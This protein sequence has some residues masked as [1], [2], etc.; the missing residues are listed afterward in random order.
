MIHG[1]GGST[2]S[3]RHQIARLARCCR[4]VAVDLPGFGYSDRPLEA[5]L[6]DRPCDTPHR[7]HQRLDLGPATI[8]GHSMGA[9]IAMRIA[10][11]RP[12]LVNRLILAA[13]VAPDEHLPAPWYTL[14]RPLAPIRWRRSG[15]RKGGCAG[16]PPPAPMTRPT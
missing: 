7:V 15:W 16:P 5:D 11:T 12:D 3:F 8:I 4:V 13:G 1:F 10:A 9:G 14:L 2:F 6:S